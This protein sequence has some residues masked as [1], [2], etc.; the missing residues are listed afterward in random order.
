M[1]LQWN[2]PLQILQRLEKAYLSALCWKHTAKLQPCLIC[3]VQKQF[4]LHIQKTNFI[5]NSA[6]TRGLG[7]V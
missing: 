5:V 3:T 6:V 1:F 2:F 4:P 7:F